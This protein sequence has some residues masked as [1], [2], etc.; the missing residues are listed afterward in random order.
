MNLAANGE[1]NGV[2]VYKTRSRALSPRLFRLFFWILLL[3]NLLVVCVSETSSYLQAYLYLKL[4]R[5]SG[6]SLLVDTSSRW[7][8]PKLSD[9][10]RVAPKSRI[11]EHIVNSAGRLWL[12]EHRYT[13]LPV[14][15]PAEWICKKRSF[16]LWPYF[17]VSSCQKQGLDPLFL[18]NYL[19]QT[20]ITFKGKACRWFGEKCRF[21]ASW[22]WVGARRSFSSRGALRHC[23]YAHPIRKGWMRFDFPPLPVRYGMKFYYGFQDRKQGDIP[24]KVRL[25]LLKTPVKSAGD[26]GDKGERILV[27][28]SIKHQ[29]GWHTHQWDK[30]SLG[31]GKRSISFET[32]TAHEGAKPFCFGGVVYQRA[33]GGKN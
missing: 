6:E 31:Q 26:K 9:A 20:K 10:V 16:G 3:G 2:K 8:L 23:V 18:R 32:W 15:L 27:E 19:K 33:K 7:F 13:G 17:E 24:M 4:I 1:T 29:P 21:G 25:R 5:K 30:D 11:P 14:M 28:R 12:F 22:K